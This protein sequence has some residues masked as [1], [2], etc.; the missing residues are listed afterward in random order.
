M[1]LGLGAA[2]YLPGGTQGGLAGWPPDAVPG[3]SPGWPPD[4]L[5][6]GSPDALPGGSPG[7]PPGGPSD[8]AL[9]AAGPGGWRYRNTDSLADYLA[10]PERG[11]LPVAEAE[12]IDQ[13]IRLRE[14]IMLAL[15]LAEGIDKERFYQRFGFWPEARFADVLRRHRRAGTLTEDRRRIRPTLEGWLQ[16]NLLAADFFA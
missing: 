14:E 10:S 4:A 13:D 16:Y 15:R 5:L 3:E 2:G 1:G 11:R 7:R 9:G 6:C 12:P 8:A